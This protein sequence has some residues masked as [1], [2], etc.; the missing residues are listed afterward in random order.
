MVTLDREEPRL[1]EGRHGRR[2]EAGYDRRTLSDPDVVLY[3][4]GVSVWSRWFVWLTGVFLLAYRPGFWYPGDVEPLSIPEPGLR[5]CAAGGGE[6]RRRP[7][8]RTVRGNHDPRRFRPAG[9]LFHLRPHSRATNRVGHA[10][11]PGNPR[12]LPQDA[13][14]AEIR[15]PRRPLPASRR[16]RKPSWVRRFD[17][18]ASTLGTSF[19]PTSWERRSS[20][21]MTKRPWR[22]S[23]CLWG[24]VLWV[25]EV[26]MTKAN[27][28]ELCRPCA[29]WPEYSP[30]WPCS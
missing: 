1:A 11:G 15:R 24:M 4:A 28:G 5:R 14:T 19:L 12:A 30:T 26:A 7:S 22:G 20:T 16:I 23:V 6:Q 10:R 21:G 18:A 8:R 27:R 25:G 29:E 17:I 9:P 3:A 2:T 13:G